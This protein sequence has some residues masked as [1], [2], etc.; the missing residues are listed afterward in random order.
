MQGTTCDELL[1]KPRFLKVDKDSVFDEKTR[2]RL[3]REN[4]ETWKGEWE[5]LRCLRTTCGVFIF[6]VR[7]KDY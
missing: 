1:E 4:D 7:F 6:F 3:Q 5:N 2:A